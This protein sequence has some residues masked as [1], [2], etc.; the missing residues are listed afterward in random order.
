MAA[1][2]KAEAKVKAFYDWLVAQRTD[3]QDLIEALVPSI[4]FLHEQLEAAK[5]R[6]AARFTHWLS[7]SRAGLLI[8]KQKK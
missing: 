1:A 7:L 5:Q 4:N 2:P 3:D 6:N 8:E